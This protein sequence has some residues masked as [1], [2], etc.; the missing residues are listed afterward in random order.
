[1]FSLQQS[2]RREQNRFCLEARGL[3]EGEGV[4]GQGGE[5]AQ[6]MYTYMNK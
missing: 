5:M 4:V 6:I 2:W 3:K 1:M